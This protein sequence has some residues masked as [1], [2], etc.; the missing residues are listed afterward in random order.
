MKRFIILTA[1]LLNIALADAP[2]DLTPKD[3]VLEKEGP[4]SLSLRLIPQAEISGQN[5]VANALGTE[6]TDEVWEARVGDMA[7][8]EFQLKNDAA[9]QKDVIYEVSFVH[10]EDDKEVF[11]T[12]IYAP[13][14]KAS[15]GQQFFDG[16]EHMVTVKALPKTQGLF[17]PI[18]AEMIV[19]VEGIDPPAGVV[20][21][22]MILLLVICAAFMVAGY[23]ISVKMASGRPE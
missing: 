21:K 16:A 4:V 10:I 2:S 15:W 19:G 5:N 23:T 11:K 22:T 9:L 3:I 7:Y 18:K 14:G 6:D 12:Q 17:K 1:L 20:I 8:L 13:Q